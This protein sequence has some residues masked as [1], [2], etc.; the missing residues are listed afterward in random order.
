MSLS[1]DVSLD[2]VQSFRL[3]R[4]QWPKQ[5]PWAQVQETQECTRSGAE[6]R[7]APGDTALSVGLG[8]KISSGPETGQRAVFI[9][10]NAPAPGLAALELHFPKQLWITS[11]MGCVLQGISGGRWGGK[12]KVTIRPFSYLR[13]TE[14]LACPGAAL[15]NTG[16]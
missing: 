10:A 7:W 3:L 4:A 14:P 9:G 5:R 12:L 1:V 2:L 6:Q 16:Q 8:P 11:A 15:V 13:S